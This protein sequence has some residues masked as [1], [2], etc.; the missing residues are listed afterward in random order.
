VTSLL[1]VGVDWPKTTAWGE[2]GYYARVFLNVQGREPEGVI[3]PEEYES[4]RDDLARRIAAIPDDAGNP[5]PTAVYTPEELYGEPQGV[6][7][8]LIVVFGD[9]LWRSVGTIGGDEGIQTLENDT[10]PDD[11]NHAQDGLY[12]VAGPGVEPRG[13]ADAHLLD[14][15]PTVLEILGI[16]RPEGMRGRSMIPALAAR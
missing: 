11:A 7:P 15:A 2:G 4:V 12:I 13:P 5:I 3:L 14:I 16:E 9:L 8:D 10:G 1:D 6:A